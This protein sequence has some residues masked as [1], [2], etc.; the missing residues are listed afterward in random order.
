MRH[1]CEGIHCR[2]C[3]GYRHGRARLAPAPGRGVLVV[4]VVVLLAGRSALA[5]A[6]AEAL[7][8][9][10][11]AAVSA[12]GLAL[13]AGTAYVTVRVRR[14]RT[15]GE[16]AAGQWADRAEVLGP[17]R[18]AV[19]SAGRVPVLVCH[20]CG[21]PIAAIGPAGTWRLVGRQALPACDHEPAMLPRADIPALPR[22]D[23]LA[24][25]RI[26]AQP[27]AVTSRDVRSL[28]SGGDR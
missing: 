20:K 23:V 28:K 6:A 14:R 7:R 27:R 18:P 22:K 15:A 1:R 2:G 26:N 12:A 25:P 4:V 8:V 21:G 10:T 19:R 13:A 17:S 11:I 9:V 3:G 24:L 16:L 5:R